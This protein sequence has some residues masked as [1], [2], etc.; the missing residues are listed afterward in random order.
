MTIRGENPCCRINNAQK[1]GVFK[2]TSDHQTIQRYCC[3]TCGK[4]FSAATN[5]P[6]KWQK[7]RQFNRTILTMLG[8]NITQTN[9]AR[10]FNLNPKTVAKKMIFLAR[11]VREEMAK[12]Q[13]Q[14]AH[15][16]AIQFD[17]LQ[18]IEHTKCKPVSVAVAVS[19]KDRKILGFEVS[20]MPATGHLARISRKK[21]GKRAD[22]RWVGLTTLF[23]QLA[24][25]LPPKIRIES[26]Q[27]PSYGPLVRTYFPE[28]N[29]TQYK[30]RKG[31][32]AGQGEMKKVGFDPL[33]SIN[34]TF[35]MMRANISRLNRRTWNTTKQLSA[36]VD[37]LSLYAW[38]HNHRL[39]PE[40]LA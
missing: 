24:T 19:K 17:E 10:C 15:I 28:A 12:E 33:F 25:V 23:D 1:H 38:R 21:Y 2:R 40:W 32:V 31:C 5:S 26:D 13:G 3:K 27:Y 37:H 18:T 6:L 34:H 11:I 7:K 16:D 30:G 22:N 9:I 36:L 20:E 14:Y 29:F 39:T 4:S 35:A 8:G